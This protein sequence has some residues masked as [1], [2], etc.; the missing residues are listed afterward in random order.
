MFVFVEGLRQNF[1]NT[2]TKPRTNLVDEN[3]KLSKTHLWAAKRPPGC[4][5]LSLSSHQPNVVEVCKEFEMTITA[6]AVDVGFLI[7][8]LAKISCHDPYFA[9]TDDHVQ[10][11]RKH[12]RCLSVHH[13]NEGVRQRRLAKKKEREEFVLHGSTCCCCSK[14]PANKD[15]YMF[16]CLLCTKPTGDQDAD[17]GMT[18]EKLFG[19]ERLAYT[20]VKGND[21][22]PLFSQAGQRQRA[23]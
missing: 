5:L 17:D 13:R 7:R 12:L 19:F 21:D 3:A 1:D 6:P 10:Q 4:I 11:H 18:S 20:D 2:Q 8:T 16:W 23:C 22:G 15:N 9:Y 14:P